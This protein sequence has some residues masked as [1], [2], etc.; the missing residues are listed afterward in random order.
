[1]YLHQIYLLSKRKQESH[2]Y[3][4]IYVSPSFESDSVKS[5]AVSPFQHSYPL[6]QHSTQALRICF[7]YRRSAAG[8]ACRCPRAVSGVNDPG[9]CGCRLRLGDHAG[10]WSR[11]VCKLRPFQVEGGPAADRDGVTV[12]RWILCR[13]GAGGALKW[14]TPL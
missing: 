14:L 13:L 3:V 7:K 4:H 1:M 6:F 8:V 2:E 11:L 10:K 12:Q 9:V 5:P